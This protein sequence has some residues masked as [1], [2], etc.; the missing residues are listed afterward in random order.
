MYLKV[1]RV[2]VSFAVV[3]K[4]VVQNTNYIVHNKTVIKKD[5]VQLP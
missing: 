4:I 3:I 2:S 1:V 5:N